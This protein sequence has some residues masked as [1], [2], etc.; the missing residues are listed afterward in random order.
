GRAV[1]DG[2][3]H[4][5]RSITHGD[6]RQ[7]GSY[8]SLTD[9]YPFRDALPDPG[10]ERVTFGF[11]GPT[12]R[13]A[14]QVAAT[15][16]EARRLPVDRV[17]ALALAVSEV[18][19]NSVRYGG[20]RGTL[21]VWDAPSGVVCDIWDTGQLHDPLVGRRRPVPDQFGGLGL[22]IANHLCDLVQVRSSPD[23]TQVRLHM[24]ALSL[25]RILTGPADG[26]S[27]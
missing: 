7:R 1:L 21:A 17:E 15:V 22:W 9:G 26:G 16:A 5:H 14:R 8:E 27:L 18:A 23:G 10:G 2:A 12:A 25:E 6:G 24:Y 4:T 11:D 20:G 3:A 13:L 19:S